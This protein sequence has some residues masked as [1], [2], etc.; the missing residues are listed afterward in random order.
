MEL[1]VGTE[2]TWS[3]RAWLCAQIAQIPV[4]VKV[5]DLTS[6]S[7][8]QRLAGKS[9]SALVPILIDG[10][11]L[12]H[13]SLAIAEYLNEI[14]H[15]AL[16]PKDSRQRAL[17]RSLCCELHS[18]FSHIRG[19][20]PLSFAAVESVAENAELNREIDRITDIFFR[21]KRPF[22]SQEPG[23]FDAFYGVL[24]YRLNQ[25]GVKLTGLAGQYQTD[26]LQWPLLQKS[27]DQARNWSC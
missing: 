21:A 24:A 23:M 25:Y 6:E 14:S 2:S 16:L 9:P 17:V 26:L 27:F 20:M 7:D 10:E 11:T 15:G 12:I 5:I 8:K 1:W 22:Y 19:Q 18:G 13:D 3:I 4:D